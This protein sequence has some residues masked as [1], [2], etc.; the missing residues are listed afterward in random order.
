MIPLACLGNKEDSVYKIERII[1]EEARSIKASPFTLPKAVSWLFSGRNFFNVCLSLT[2]NN[3]RL[4]GEFPVNHQL[5][6]V[7][8]CTKGMHACMFECEA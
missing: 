6:Y 5:T 7:C 1:V 2:I 8:T 3:A 4:R